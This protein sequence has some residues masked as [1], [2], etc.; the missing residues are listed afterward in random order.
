MAQLYQATVQYSA[1]R[2]SYPNIASFDR[3]NGECRGMDE[4]AQ[5]VDKKIHSLNFSICISET[6]LVSPFRHRIRDCV[7]QAAVKRSKFF[8]LDRRVVVESRI[9]YR[10]AQ[11]TVVADNLLNRVSLPA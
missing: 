3:N 9:R 7:V 5:F 1:G 10:L 2:P 11:I 4:L 8:N 6:V